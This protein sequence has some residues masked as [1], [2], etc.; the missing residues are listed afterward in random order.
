MIGCSGA[1]MVVRKTPSP[2]DL[3]RAPTSYVDAIRAECLADHPVALDGIVR[4]AIG[5]RG[6]EEKHLHTPCPLARLDERL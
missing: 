1:V 3:K 6:S 2:W 5:R 4:R